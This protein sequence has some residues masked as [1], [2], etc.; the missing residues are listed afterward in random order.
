MHG[1]AS[2][3]A[4]GSLFLFQGGRGSVLVNYPPREEIHLLFSRDFV[5]LPQDTSEW[6]AT[7]QARSLEPLVS[8]TSDGAVC[9]RCIITDDV[10][11]ADFDGDG[12][13]FYCHL[14]DKLDRQNA[15]GQRAEQAFESFVAELKRDGVGKKYD[16][17]MGV[18]GG[19]DSSYLAHL[20]VERGVRPLAVH[21]DNTWNSPVAT[22]NIFAV[23]GKLNIDLET[24]VVD[25]DEYDDLYL[26]FLKAGVKDIEAPTDIGFMGTL[27]RAAE[28]HGLKH[29]VE[30]HSFRTEGVSPLGWLYM[31][32]GYIKDVHRK[33]G[34]VPLRTFPNMS[35]AQ[36][37]RWSLFSGIKRT[38]PLYWID[39]KKEETKKGLHNWKNLFKFDKKD[40]FWGFFFIALFFTI[41]A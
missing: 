12:V 30:G 2:A 17:V 40:I 11:G 24:Y 21:F 25:N 27:Y 37:M 39:Y 34:R 28:N 15:L 33:F 22:S 36:F 41:W 13:C 3:V 16:C 19:T 9:R 7:V 20:L 23:L 35:F 14:H 26:S 1:G 5:D 31:D 29:I 10:P 6:S 32:G 18:S 4:A 38:R 8:E